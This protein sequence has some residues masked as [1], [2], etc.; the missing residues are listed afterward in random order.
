MS[1][2]VLENERGKN[3]IKRYSIFENN[4]WMEKQFL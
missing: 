4:T 3:A 1:D 2:E